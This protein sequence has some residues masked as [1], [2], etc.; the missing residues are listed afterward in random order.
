MNLHNENFT[1]G[2]ILDY[3]KNP[4]KSLLFFNLRKDLWCIALG[5]LIQLHMYAQNYTKYGKITE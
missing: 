4:L 1:T 5:S 3:T 2:T